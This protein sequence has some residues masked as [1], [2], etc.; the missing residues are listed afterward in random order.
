MLY[1]IKSA[2]IINLKNDVQLRLK[3]AMALGIMERA[4]YNHLL[5][6]IKEPFPNSNFTK[7]SA[8][9]CFEELGYPRNDVLTLEQPA[10]P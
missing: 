9:E 2:M 4:V 6:Y 10:K 1:Y 3:I 7:I 8:L 5:R